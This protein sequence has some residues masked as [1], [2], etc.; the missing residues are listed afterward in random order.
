VVV[1]DVQNLEVV[2]VKM[3][4]DILLKLNLKATQTKNDDRKILPNFYAVNNIRLIVA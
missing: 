1:Y 3:A 4:G 2:T